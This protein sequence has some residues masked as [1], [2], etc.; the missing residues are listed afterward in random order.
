MKAKYEIGSGTGPAN[1]YFSQKEIFFYFT[2]Y[3]VQ[4]LE[5]REQKIIEILRLDFLL[6][7]NTW[8]KLKFCSLI[9]VMK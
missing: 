3:K 8:N 4:H 2:Q 1:P 5:E 7:K 9:N 6:V